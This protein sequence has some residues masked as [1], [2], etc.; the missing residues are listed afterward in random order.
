ML[1]VNTAAQREQNDYY[2]TD[3]KAIEIA[4]PIL[5]ECGLCNDVWE[6]ACGA[7]HISEVLKQHGYNVKSTDLVDRGYGEVSDFL[8]CSDTFNGDILTNPPFRHAVE[9]IRHG[10]QLI[11]P[12]RKLFL[13]LKI[14]F[15]ESKQRKQLFAEYP[16]RYVV[17]Y[18]E[19]QQTAKN[20]EFEKYSAASLCFAW[21]IFERGFT[22]RPEILWV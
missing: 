15:L 5:V 1:G 4:L 20:A 18:S 16:P 14:Q 6:C 10:M 3:P 7:G 22:G 17:V 13:F 8:K 9:F 12:G 11:S 19:R 2:A 21:F